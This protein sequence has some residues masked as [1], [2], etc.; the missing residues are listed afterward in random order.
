MGDRRIRDL[1]TNCLYCLQ[2]SILQ[3]WPLRSIRNKPQDQDI[4]VPVGATFKRRYLHSSRCPVAVLFR[5]RRMLGMTCKD[6]SNGLS[7]IICH[8]EFR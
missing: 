8:V 2:R 5:G 3:D 7:A 1:G 6:N 4:D